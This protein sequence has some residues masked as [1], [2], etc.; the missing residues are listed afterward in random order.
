MQGNELTE[1][2]GVGLIESVTS[3]HG[4]FQPK[5][6][7]VCSNTRKGKGIVVIT[8]TRMVDQ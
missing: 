6:H 7:V 2:T 4:L 1:D 5:I 8:A 3:E